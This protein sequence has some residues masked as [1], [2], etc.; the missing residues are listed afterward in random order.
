M[1][2]TELDLKPLLSRIRLYTRP[3]RDGPSEENE[4]TFKQSRG[5]HHLPQSR[6][7]FTPQGLG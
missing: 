7:L 2:T 1:I 6:T 4:E 3:G 5:V